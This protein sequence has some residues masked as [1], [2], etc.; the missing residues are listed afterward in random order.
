MEEQPRSSLAI[1][2]DALWVVTAP[3]GVPTY[4][5][6]FEAFFACRHPIYREGKIRAVA[7]MG[8]A[9]D[10][11]QRYR[12]LDEEGIRLVHTPEEYRRT[13]ELPVWYPLLEDL[14]P[15]S[16]WFDRRPSAVDVAA[17]FR[18]PVF[19]KGER[20]TSK[21]QR[22]LA[23]IEGPEEFDRAMDAWEADPILRWQRIVCREFL[24]LRLVAKPSNHAMP[25]AFEFRTFWWNGHC[26]GHGRYWSGHSYGMTPHE[27]SAALEIAAEA[28]RRINVTFLVVDVAQR[29]DGKWVVIECNDGQDSG[30]AGVAPFLMWRQV[31]DRLDK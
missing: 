3:T 19:M 23:I 10:Y 22:K 28:A 11:E 12:S 20:Q 1:V 18:W 24:D 7:R 4:D 14:T 8:A 5:F 15:R 31:L 6:E 21:H 13:S 9:S 16:A 30:Y 25:P 17:S 29:S 26:V 2:E 27:Q